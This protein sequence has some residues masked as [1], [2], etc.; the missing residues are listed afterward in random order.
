MKQFDN[1]PNDLGAE[2]PKSVEATLQTITQD[3]R[4][5]QQNFSGQLS[6]DLERLQREKARLIQDIEALQEEYQSLQTDYK[7]LQSDH[8]AA[9]SSQQLAQQQVWAKRLAQALATHLQAHL[10]HSLYPS[11]SDLG[12]AQSPSPSFPAGLPSSLENAYQLLSSLDSTLNGALQSLQQDLNGYQSSLS[13]QISRMHSMERQGEAILEALVNR[14]SQQ[15]QT[16]LVRPP[17]KPS[18]P[19]NGYDGSAQQ[20][21]SHSN[22]QVQPISFPPSQDSKRSS[23]TRAG[24]LRGQPQQSPQMS[25]VKRKSVKLFGLPRGLILIILS[26]LALAIHYVLVSVVW[27]GGQI[28][29]L[30]A[31]ESVMPLNF[32]NALLLLWVRMIIV[33]SLT[34]WLA[35]QLYPPVWRDIRRFFTARDRRSLFQ[36]IG[37]GLFLFLAQAAIFMAIAQVGPG[38]AI[39]LLF[40]YPLI[41][42]PLAWFVFGDR[43]SP[44]RIVV[45]I[46]IL[47]GIVFTALP[48][49]TMDLAGGGVSISGIIKALFAGCAFAV[50]VISMQ[51][52]FRKL[53]PVPVSLVQYIAIFI[54]TTLLLVIHL[55]NGEFQPPTGSLPG[56]G[57]ALGGLLLGVLAV[58]DYFCNNYGR[59]FIR[60]VQA[61]IIASCGPILTAILAVIII[62]GEISSLGVVQWVGI[63]LVTIGVIALSLERM[64]GQEKKPKKISKQ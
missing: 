44:L 38:V 49:I 5:L 55:F 58:L 22:F 13:Q 31:I 20:R 63:I 50:Y 15:L 16:E 45:M 12:T 47:M 57:L 37:S 39:T 34:P 41:T 60:A 23:E 1:L 64:A 25:S 30:I 29:G 28:F 35:M 53:H 3:L 6:Q 21:H 4:N 18:L 51:M 42:V 56:L 48:E 36:I 27:N 61:P 32:S 46:A 54:I 9:L 14:L 24:A 17:L 40:M 7:S 43:P 10:T 19:D 62:P 33:L 2:V 59:Q 26:T 52:G 11:A 8:K